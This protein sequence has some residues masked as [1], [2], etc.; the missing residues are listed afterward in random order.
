MIMELHATIR[1]PS[2][3]GSF[4]PYDREQLEQQ[5]LL[6]LAREK[7]N[8]QRI[9]LNRPLLGGI[10]PHAGMKYCAVQA[11]HFFE[12]LRLTG[13]QPDTVVLAHPNH[14]GQGPAMSV[15]DHEYWQTPLGKVAVDRSF[16]EALQ[17]PV[18]SRIQD[19]EHS[20]EVIL[21]YLQYF[22]KPGFRIVAVNMLQQ[23]LQM[24]TRLAWK[25]MAAQSQLPRKLLFIASSDFSHYLPPA[26]ARR[27]DAFVLQEI[28]DRN[29]AGVQQAVRIH[30]A[31]PCGHGP[32]MALMEYSR[33]RDPHYKAL[34]LRQGHSGEVVPMPEVVR[35]VA[36]AMV[37][38]DQP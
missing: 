14:Y 17:L 10:V 26:E 15:D 2:V 34:I 11:V 19:Q 8:L 37:E 4:Y 12:Q 33:M 32:I 13:Q 36:M 20:A 27:R 16:A 6:A 23:T 31:T 3:A 24:A 1:K 21:P 7:D 5:M 30:Q 18:D 29:A 22:L 35:Y 9:T 25:V 38:G 28:I